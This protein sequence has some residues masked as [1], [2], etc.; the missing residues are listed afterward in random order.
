MSCADIE[1][2]EVTGPDGKPTQ[3]LKLTYDVD[4]PVQAQNGYWTKLRGLDGSVYDHLEFD[5]KCDDELGCSSIFKIELKKYKDKER[6]ELIRGTQVVTG[7]GNEWKHISLKLNKFTGIMDFGDPAVWQNPSLGRKDLEEFVIVFK[8]RQADKKSGAILVDNIKFIQKNDPGP[9]AVDAPSRHVEKTPPTRF[10]VLGDQEVFSGEAGYK[11]ASELKRGD[12][13]IIFR[14]G[15]SE[16]NTV[17]EEKDI[18]ED[19]ETYVMTVDGSENFIAGYVVW[20]S[21]SELLSPMRTNR[22]RVSNTKVTGVSS[23]LITSPAA[24]RRLAAA[25]RLASATLASI[26][27]GSSCPGMRRI[28]RIRSAAW[29]F[30]PLA[31]ASTFSKYISSLGGIS[32]SPGSWIKPWT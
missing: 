10:A 29:I 8:D 11:K 1:V 24:K 2:V 26:R 4:S 15:K 3:A 18:A 19:V 25:F 12:S 5:V 9:T 21:G 30:R 6:T 23:T 32:Y 22:W 20:K 27:I 28:M 17:F 16:R 7:I 31:L 13:V 14:N